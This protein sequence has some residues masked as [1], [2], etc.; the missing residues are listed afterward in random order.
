MRKVSRSS[1]AATDSCTFA[2]PGEACAFI[3]SAYLPIAQAAVKFTFFVPSRERSSRQFGRAG[4]RRWVIF[5][6]PNALYHHLGA[7]DPGFQIWE[8]ELQRRAHS[9]QPSRFIPSRS[10]CIGQKLKPGGSR[11]SRAGRISMSHKVPIPP[12]A[13]RHQVL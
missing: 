3:I 9:R 13:P 8:T 4:L 5:S 2:G 7:S 12:N 10:S 11:A 1:S 6:K